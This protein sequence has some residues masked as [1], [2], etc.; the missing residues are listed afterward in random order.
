M[1]ECE[2]LLVDGACSLCL[3]KPHILESRS[4]AGI[5]QSIQTAG[6]EVGG[7]FAVHLTKSMANEIF[8]A[9]RSVLPSYTQFLDH[10]LSGH[11]LALLIRKRGASSVAEVVEDFRE[12]C[13][14]FHSELAKALRPNSLRGKFG[15]DGCLNAVHCTDISDDGAVECKYFF[16][17]LASL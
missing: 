7:A 1:K 14:P 4:E 13:G 16:E 15:I 5:I 12:F 10:L 8:D 2:P 3:L 11:S 17:T 6:F 9:Y